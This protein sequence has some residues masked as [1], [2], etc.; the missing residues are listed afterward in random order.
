MH[1]AG[2]R[3]HQRRALCSSTALEPGAVVVGGAGEEEVDLTQLAGAEGERGERDG[4]RS[5]TAR[6][7]AA[8]KGREEGDAAGGSATREAVVTT[9]P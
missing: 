3:E 5:R 2:R 9:Q 4:S 7:D 8:R 6:H 1:L